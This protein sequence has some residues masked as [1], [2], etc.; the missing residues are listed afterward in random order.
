[1]TAAALELATYASAR[2][3]LIEA[4]AIIDPPPIRSAD[5][6][7]DER[8]I[9]PL[10]NAEPGPWRSSRV[11]WTRAIS[12]AFSDPR[13]RT[14]VVV[15]GAQM[16]KTETILNVIG[17]RFDDGPRVPTLYV[18]PTE[19]QVRGFCRERLDPMLRSV[20]TIVAKMAQG[21]DDKVIEK[22][23]GGVRL[24][25]AWAGSATELASRPCGLVLVDERDRMESS[26]AGEGDPVELAAARTATFPGGKLGIFS[27]PTL[28]GHSPIVALFDTGTREFWCWPCMHCGEYFRP[29]A[30]LLIFDPTL[31]RAELAASARVVCPACGGEHRDEHKPTLNAGG[32]FLPHV[33]DPESPGEYKPAPAL[34]LADVRSVWVSG[35]CS[36]WQP[37]G[38]L[39][40]KLATA[41]KSKDPDK[42]QAVINVAFGETFRATGDAPKAEQVRSVVVRVPRRQVP[43]W[44][45]L[46]TMGV[47]VQ[48]TGLW[49]AV[50]AFGFDHA[51]QA[52]RSHAID[53]GFIFGDPEYDD[54]WIA[55]A[56][57]RDAEYRTTD[58]NGARRVEL[59]LCDSGFNPSTDRYRRPTH[60]VYEACRRSLWRML[61]SKGHD[62]QKSPAYLSK[63]ESLPSGRVIPGLR[64]WHVD[65]DH[66]KSQIHAAI[67]RA[68]EEPIP[69]WTLHAEADDHYLEQLIAE[70]LLITSAGR[71]IWKLRGRADNHLF[72]CE[73]LT[74]A[75][76]WI[77]QAKIRP[78]AG[79]QVRSA[80]RADALPPAPPRA[81]GAPGAPGA[82]GAP[83]APGYLKR[84]APGA[85]PWIRPR[86]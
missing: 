42:L 78:P 37:F 63:I 38:T 36:P 26:T 76:A 64:L 47:D 14:V 50:R 32:R 72:D 17:H 4:A 54:V 44:A 34:E 52:A 56:N 84:P 5:E 55:L 40:L 9:L 7:A 8:R 70:E 86:R 27:T 19:N 48:K 28:E 1:M 58:G 75:A 82:A 6:W 65:T 49:Y 2:P 71:R 20:P 18:G 25:G 51:A 22:F 29:R 30:R 60:A 53:H 77:H 68:A 24:G 57:V 10:G 35:L 67:R 85:P 39:A 13:V 81:P 59:A 21:H 62:R 41:Q 33:P 80:P 69:M 11:P 43:T 61:P 15:M 45:R 83:G 12:Q 74:H 16:G 79:D 46:L 66:F 31:P 23:I 73:V 3:L